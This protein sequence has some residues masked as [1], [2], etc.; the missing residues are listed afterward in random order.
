MQIDMSYVDQTL[1]NIG[2]AGINIL[3]GWVLH[4][5]WSAVRDLQE[6]DK[7]LAKDVKSIEVIV[8]GEYLKR[9]EF[10]EALIRIFDKLDAIDSKLDRK[11]DK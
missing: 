7:E 2:F 10:N 4:T 9:A 1:V 6:A 8:A 3:G 5:V 11:A